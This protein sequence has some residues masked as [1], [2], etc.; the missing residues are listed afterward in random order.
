MIIEM[1]AWVHPEPVEKVKPR[2]PVEKVKDAGK[3]LFSMK[4][5]HKVPRASR[6]K[7]GAEGYFLHVLLEGT[8]PDSAQGD[9]QEKRINQATKRREDSQQRDTSKLIAD[10]ESLLSTLKRDISST[11]VARHAKTSH[12]DAAEAEERQLSA[13]AAFVNTLRTW[14]V[15]DLEMTPAENGE[16]P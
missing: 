12:A 4:H 14:A 16:S 9:R 5:N 2:T 6:A 11:V 1:E 8:P 7:A 3:L 15:K 10:M 13:T